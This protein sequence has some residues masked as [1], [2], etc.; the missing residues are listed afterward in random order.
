MIRFL[1]CNTAITLAFVEYH[2]GIRKETYVPFFNLLTTHV[3]RKSYIT[4]SLIIGIPERVV[5]EVSG[6][7]SEK[8]FRRYVNLASSYKDEVIRR[9]YST[10]NI[11]KFIK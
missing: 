2:D 10:E 6:H 9:S 1:K 5:K 8:D 3:A 4:N 11:S 7:K